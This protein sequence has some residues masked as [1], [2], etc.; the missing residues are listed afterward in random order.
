[1]TFTAEEKGLLKYLLPVQGNIRTLE[2]VES[3]VAKMDAS[4]DEEDIVFSNNEWKL[5]KISINMKDQNGII[6][7]ECLNLVRKIL[8]GEV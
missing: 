5:L 1:L 2:L 3:V 6:P 8:K 4:A 7:Y